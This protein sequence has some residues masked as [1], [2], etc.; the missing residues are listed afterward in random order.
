M[1]SLP[2]I[3]Q[4]R[5]R[6]PKQR[7]EWENGLRCEHTE[8][9]NRWKWKTDF[10]VS[11]P[12]QRTKWENGLRRVST[13]RQR[14]CLTVELCSSLPRFTKRHLSTDWTRHEPP[15]L[16]CVHPKTKNKQTS[17]WCKIREESVVFFFFSTSCMS[18]TSFV[19]WYPTP[20]PSIRSHQV[21]W[22]TRLLLSSNVTLKQSTLLSPTL[23]FHSIF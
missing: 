9:M 8:T 17:L 15:W 3:L 23:F 14:N 1:Y 6:T 20:S 13:K 16:I 19:R 5:L 4:S 2:D 21:F 18:P 12:K 7:T 22:S 11:T 10:A